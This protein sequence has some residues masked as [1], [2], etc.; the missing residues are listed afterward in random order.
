VQELIDAKSGHAKRFRNVG[1]SPLQLAFYRGALVGARDTD[2][3]IT[4][5]DRYTAGQ[6][7]SKLWENRHATATCSWDR[8]GGAR[9]PHWWTDHIADASDAIRRLRARM[10]GKNF[11][12]VQRFCGEGYSMADSIR[13]VVEVHPNAVIARVR[14]ALDDLVTAMTGRRVQ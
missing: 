8:V 14:E 3:G 12:I 11:L 10:Y 9:D 13:G 6:R 5:E 2:S 4:A 7:F 1:S